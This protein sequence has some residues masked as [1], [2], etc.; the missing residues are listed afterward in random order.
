MK[1]KSY[2][3]DKVITSWTFASVKYSFYKRHKAIYNNGEI[4]IL[5]LTHKEKKEYRKY[6]SLI[7]PFINLETV[8]ITKSLTG[9]F[10]KHII[11]EEFYPLY[12]EPC[13]NSD[14]SIGFLQNKSIYNKWFDEGLF[15][16]DFF[17]KIDDV[18]YTNNFNIIEDIESYIDKY[19]HEYDF[20]LVIKPN[21][22]SYGGA[23]IYFVNSRKEIKTIIKLHKNLVTQEKLVQS[24]LINNF[25]KDSI[26]T[27]RV[28][29]YKDREGAVHL[30]NASIR[31]GKDG[32][33]DNA[34]AGGIVCNIKNNGALNGYAVDKYARK[35]FKHPNSGFIFENKKLPFYDD[36]ENVSIEVAEKIIGVRL[37]S[38]DMALDSNN[39]WRCIEINLFGQT[40]RFAQYAGEPFFGE[41]TTDIINELL[42][43]D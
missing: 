14:K 2:L 17:H 5:A 19:I 27:V 9:T 36:L 26:N 6:W 33:L 37:I 21:K 25:N 32:S 10:N 13:L 24:E 43:N 41:M 15:P 8:E 1:I 34:S 31:M 40:I 42:N 4:N 16:K 18:Y 29:I 38:L 23:D 11:P 28:C 3:K 12:F 20:P 22:D 35:Y 39:K 7:S 30:L